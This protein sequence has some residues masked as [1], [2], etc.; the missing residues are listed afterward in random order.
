MLGLY[1]FEQTSFASNI[2]DTSGSNNNGTNLGGSSIAAGKYC[3]GFDGNGTNTSST[4]SNAFSSN[5]DLDAQ[6]GLKG[7]IS[8]WYKSNAN[9]NSGGYNGGERTLFDAST[10]ISLGANNKYFQLGIESNGRLRFTF[11]DSND[12]DYNLYEPVGTV[13]S[14]HTW[15]YLTVTWNYTADSYQLYVNGSL[16]QSATINTNG[17]IKDLGAIIFGDNASLYSQNN[18]SSLASQTSANGQFDEV[19]IY[20]KVLTSTEIQ[21]DM[22]DNGSCFNIDHYQIEHDGNGLTCLA[23][24]VTIKACAN[25]SCSNL[26]ADNA[27]LNFQVAGVTQ[28][29][30]SF[31][32]STTVNFNHLVAETVTLSLTNASP[33]PTNATVCKNS[34]S[35]N[36]S[37]NIVFSEAGFVLD[38]NNGANVESCTT[39]NLT[40]KAVKLSDNGVSC[41]PAFTGNQNLSF[42]F[43]Y[44]NPNT[45]TK[46]PK[47]N[48]GSGLANLAASG[49]SQN[50]AV[51]FNTAGQ[52]ILPL[53]YADAGQLKFTVAE[54]SSTGVS[55][56]NITKT[57]YPNKLVV[58]ASNSL[59]VPQPLNSVNSSGINKQ[60][61]GV[62]FP[63]NIA[64]QCANGTTTPNYTPQ[65]TS[66]LQLSVQQKL[67]TTFA[68]SLAITGGSTVNATN[69]TTTNWAAINQSALNFTANYSEVGIINI[70]AK[71][72]NYFGSIINAGGVTNYTN[73]GRFIP[74]HFVL[75]SSSV[76]GSCNGFTYM[77]EPKLQ[78]TYQLEAQNF[79]SIKTQNYNGNFVHSIVNLIA[80]N[81]N[82][83]SELST[84]L[85]GATGVWAN[86]LYNNNNTPNAAN[87]TFSRKS[88]PAAVDGP[89]DNLRIGVRLADNDNSVL[90]NLDMKANTAGA[91]TTGV[92]I[93]TDCDTKSL[94][95]ETKLRFG[96]L[97]VGNAYGPETS[98]LP[99]PLTTQ[100]WNGSNYVTNT[101]DNCTA[102]DGLPTANYTLT[103][104]GL[105]PALPTNV[106]TSSGSGTFASGLT[107]ILLSA[108][109]NN[110]QGQIRYTYDATPIWL[111]G[112]W[113]GDG[114]FNNKPSAVASFGIFRGNDRIIYWREIHQ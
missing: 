28:S 34:A 47:L 44:I 69:L 114:N 3:R 107:E 101:L 39:P 100:Y 42:I 48:S 18:N 108:P 60:K 8:F 109:T 74:D 20:R 66:A 95:A 76:T 13:R 89:Y 7:T 111:Q 23:E 56:A 26:S 19:R 87:W 92:A 83:G 46:V 67:P 88:L 14:S 31:T 75:K 61:A 12:G 49:V 45:G 98:P 72:I 93:N 58:S 52:A 65:S 78:L 53:T 35:A 104:S 99:L 84:R 59:P 77:D 40:I 91:C 97:L 33:T 96:R 70:A 4:T 73:V 17:A 9:W 80:E 110:A 21:T 103:N 62:N 37:C 63:I 55:S 102:Y 11:E 79:G 27:S 50:R 38:V 112:D 85:S 41:A 51:T 81:A 25:A 24:T 36:N 68:G 30:P 6:V 113:N 94:G 106:N 82:S 10:N 16:V 54:V 22:N 29:S 71:D 57:F 1:K 86:G 90:T 2:T 105:N 15:Y 5:I 43:N 32:G 64:A